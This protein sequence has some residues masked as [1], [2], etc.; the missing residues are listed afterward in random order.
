M[1]EQNIHIHVTTIKF[2]CTCR[3][4]DSKQGQ[5]DAFLV[6][7]TYHKVLAVIV[8]NIIMMEVLFICFGNDI[9]KVHPH[10]VNAQ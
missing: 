4:I 2:M 1:H 6:K 5:G 10:S 7:R 3:A 9:P 8:I